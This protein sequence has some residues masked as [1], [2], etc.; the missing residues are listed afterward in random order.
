MALTSG[1]VGYYK[2]DESS[3][4][5]SD[6]VGTN[7]L[8][9]T[10]T[11]YGAEKINNGA[12]FNGSAKLVG[13]SKPITTVGNWTFAMWVNLAS[14]SLSG[15]FLHN[16][17][18]SPEEGISIG[19]GNGTFS[20]S[21]GNH[22][23][24]LLDQVV[25]DDS[26]VNIGTGLHHVA[27]TKGASGTAQLFYIDGALVF[28]GTTSDP[29]NNAGGVLQLGTDTTVSPRQFTG[30]LDEVGVWSR[31][32]SG[33]EI[34]QLYNAGAGVQYPFAIFGDDYSYVMANAS[35]YG[36]PPRQA[37]Y[38]QRLSTY[39]TRKY[40]KGDARLSPFTFTKALTEGAIGTDTVLKATQRT[41][42]EGAIGTDSVATQ[43]VRPVTL[44]EGVIGIDA[45]VRS[46]VKLLTDGAI[47][48]DSVMRTIV[49]SLSEG[50]IGTDSINFVK[51]LVRTMSEGIIGTD[52][53][54]RL[55]NGAD[56]IWSHVSK[57]ADAVWG[58]A[59]KA[60]NAVWTHLNVS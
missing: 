23:I 29:V 19:V 32:L 36:I 10:S 7:T 2:L 56:I 17:N 39:F 37:A 1:I 15:C 11:T 30:A 31:Q 59:T 44:T 27:I 46:I 58:K 51:A 14:A 4:N 38:A 33:T 25:W 12:V 22:L 49:K 35:N 55:K 54:K 52:S 13:G 57:S 26:G 8:T 28:T 53:V 41:L 34:G 5:A 60:V 43:K 16:G 48:T 47:G 24:V 3:G 18:N 45:V 40:A 50:V 9:N 6:S 42:A 20:S 21:P